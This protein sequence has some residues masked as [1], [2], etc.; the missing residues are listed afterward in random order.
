MPVLY[1]MCGWLMADGIKEEKTLIK[2]SKKGGGGK[3]LEPKAKLQGSNR[4][5]LC[6]SEQSNKK[7]FS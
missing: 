1:R 5:I 7:Y 3:N 4:G 6:H 2:R